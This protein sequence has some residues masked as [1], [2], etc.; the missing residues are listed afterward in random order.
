M[1]FYTTRRYVD[2]NGKSVSELA[3]YY[4]PE[5]ARKIV[6]FNLTTSKSTDTPV[7]RQLTDDLL[8]KLLESGRIPLEIFLKNCSIP[9]AEKIQAELKTFSEQA[10]AGRSTPTGYKCYNRQ[11]SK[12]P[13]P[14][15]W[16]C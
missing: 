3:K 10:A 16:I 7:F 2:I 5:M 9:G 14:K 4:E 13:T 12:T 6:D 1:Q 8:M 15:R 11:P